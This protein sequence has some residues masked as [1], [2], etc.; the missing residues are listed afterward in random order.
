[1]NPEQACVHGHVPNIFSECP[2]CAAPGLL[3]SGLSMQQERIVVSLKRGAPPRWTVRLKSGV[4]FYAVCRTLGMDWDG[5]E[6]TSGYDDENVNVQSEASGGPTIRSFT[7]AEKRQ[8][9]QRMI[10]NWARWGG[11][12]ATT[13][14]R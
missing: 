14:K 8:V 6:P 2:Q 3:G 7:P 10:Q 5:G 4:A 9:A 1:M 12:R 13:R 11:L